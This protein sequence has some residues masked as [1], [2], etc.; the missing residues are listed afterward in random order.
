MK[1]YIYI[2]AFLFSLISFAQN[3]NDLYNYYDGLKINEFYVG[4]R[5]E[6]EFHWIEFYNQSNHTIDLHKLYLTSSKS[7]LTMFELDE[8]T[9]IEAG[10]FI[11]IYLNK[12]PDHKEQT[13]FVNINNNEKYFAISYQSKE[14]NFIIDEV[15]YKETVEGKSLM[16]LSIGRYPNGDGPWLIMREKT[17][18]AA[19][20]GLISNT[21][22]TYT[23]MLGVKMQYGLNSSRFFN[24]IESDINLKLYPYTSHSLGI[25]YRLNISYFLLIAEASYTKRAYYYKYKVSDSTLKATFT[26]ETTGRQKVGAL[27]IGVSSGVNLRSKLNVFIGGNIGVTVMSIFSYSQTTTATLFKKDQNG[28]DY[29]EELKDVYNAPKESNYTSSDIIKVNTFIGIR[30]QLYQHLH[31][32]FTYYNDIVGI[33]FEDE[34][35]ARSVKFRTFL[36][37]IEI[38]ITIDKC[39][40]RTVF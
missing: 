29:T 16:N 34:N 31:A 11:I 35:F 18:K 20:E 4:E 19:N 12:V 5:T 33:N 27:E 32:T 3:D 28:N 17:P 21:F 38:P 1:Y 24:E 15:S 26:K 8:H 6:N 10:E 39:K 9:K 22:Y 25:F 7:E 23:S 14:L 30:Y 2:C 37:G 36:L 40:A 13:A